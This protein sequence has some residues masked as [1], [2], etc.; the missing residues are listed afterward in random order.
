MTPIT[1]AN[2]GVIRAAR[3]P[4][5]NAM[6]T[7]ATVTLPPL[8]QTAHD[9]LGQNAPDHPMLDAVHQAFYMHCVTYVKQLKAAGLY[10][11]PDLPFR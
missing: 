2:E 10:S 7:F 4:A 6:I 11:G 3:N 5:H 1:T 8:A 9:T